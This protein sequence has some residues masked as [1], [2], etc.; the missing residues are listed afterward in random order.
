[1]LKAQAAQIVEN[2]IDIS[3]YFPAVEKLTNRLKTMDPGGHG[4]IFHIFNARI[5]PSSIWHVKMLRMECKD[6]LSH[7]NAFDE[8][9]RE[10]HHLRMVK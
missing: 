1:E 9:R 6:L 8:W 3:D 5:S 2:P 4:S 7:L 10:K